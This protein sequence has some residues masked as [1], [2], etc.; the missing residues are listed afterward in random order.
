MTVSHY[1]AISTAL[2]ISTFDRDEDGA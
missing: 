2:P 1:D